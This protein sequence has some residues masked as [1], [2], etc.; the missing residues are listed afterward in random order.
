[1]LLQSS[2]RRLFSLFMLLSMTI[3]PAFTDHERPSLHHR[4][5]IEE[6]SRPI[7]ITQQVTA[8]YIFNFTAHKRPTSDLEKDHRTIRL[9]IIPPSAKLESQSER[10]GVLGRGL[11][12]GP[13]WNKIL[14][15]V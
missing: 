2:V 8:N 15:D 11:Q 5:I 13:T 1:M 3:L 14:I 4:H 9:V 12:N 7:K 6:R 10:S